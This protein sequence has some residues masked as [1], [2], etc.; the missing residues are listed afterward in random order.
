MSTLTQIPTW[1]S[2]TLAKFANFFATTLVIIKTSKIINTL[3][4]LIAKFAAELIWTAVFFLGTF[5][6][7]SLKQQI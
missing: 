6:L 3:L 7:K 1:L 2:F 4:A 5:S